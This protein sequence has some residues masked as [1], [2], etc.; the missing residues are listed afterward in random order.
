MVDK[1]NINTDNKKIN[2]C[3]KKTHADNTQMNDS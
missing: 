2:D 3:W 1:T